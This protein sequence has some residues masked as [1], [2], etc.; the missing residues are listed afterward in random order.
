MGRRCR[1]WPLFVFA[2]LI[3]L[4]AVA[5][6]DD[7]EAV[8]EEAPDAPTDRVVERDR[9][10]AIDVP[11]VA[12]VMGDDFDPDDQA[13]VVDPQHWSLHMR[14]AGPPE[15]MPQELVIA[16]D[17]SV[18]RRGHPAVGEGTRLSIEGDDG[19][20]ASVEDWAITD[21][22]RTLRATLGGDLSP[23]TTYTATLEALEFDFDGDEDLEFID[24]DEPFQATFDTPATRL[25]DVSPVRPVGS[26]GHVNLTFSTPVDQA[27]L[28]DL[29]WELDGASV[30]SVTYES[31][32]DRH[33][34]ARIQSTSTPFRMANDAAVL[35][36]APQ[37]ESFERPVGN[38]SQAIA[39]W[40]TGLYERADTPT[41]RVICH[42]ESLDDTRGF[43]WDSEIRTSL[44]DISTRCDLDIERLLEHIAIDVDGSV[45]VAEHRHGVDLLFDLD[46][47]QGPVGLA[48]RSG[49]WADDGMPLVYEGI[50]ELLSPSHPGPSIHL[51]ADGRYLRGDDWSRVPIRHR[52]VEWVRVLVRH[53]ADAHFGFWLSGGDELSPDASFAVAE[54]Y[55]QFDPT[56]DDEISYIDL[57]ALVGDPAP[58][59]YQI[60]VSA[61]FHG[62]LQD[63]HRLLVSDVQL[64]AKRASHDDQEV[65]EVWAWTLDA[66]SAQPVEDTPLELVRSNGRVLAECRTD[67]EGFCKLSGN[68]GDLENEPPIA[69]VAEGSNDLAYIDWEDTRTE[70][71]EGDIDGAPYSDTPPYRGAIA[72]ER[73]LYRPGETLSLAAAIRGDGLSA[74]ADLPVGIELTDARQQRAFSGV[75][76]ADESGALEWTY[77]IP[78]MAPTGTWTVELFSGD[79]TIA[80]QDLTVEEFVPDRIDVDLDLDERQVGDALQGTLQADYFF[81]LPASDNRYEIECHFQP[82]HPFPDEWPNYHFGPF[83]DE[84]SSHSTRHS[85]TLDDQGQA[86]VD[87]T[88]DDG[89]AAA[90][91]VEVTAAVFEG[92]SGRPARQ[93]SS[94]HLITDEPLVGLRSRD[95]RADADDGARLQGVVVDAAGQ[96][97]DG[98]LE[99]SMESGAIRYSTVRTH[100]GGRTQW[101]RERH[102]SVDERRA[103]MVNDG[104]FSLNLSPR[105]INQGIYARVALDGQFTELDVDPP[106]RHWA[107]YGHDQDLDPRPDDPAHLP[108]EG[109]DEVTVGEPATFSFD[110]PSEGRALVATET[111]RVDSWQ[112]LDV[113]P[114]TNEWTVELDSFDPNIYVSALFVPTGDD[115]PDEMDRAFGVTRVAVNRDHWRADLDLHV[116]SERQ[117]GEMLEISV[118]APDAGP[119]A[120]VAIAAVDRGILSMATISVDDPID[121]LFVTRALGTTTFDTVGWYADVS[122]ERFGG[123]AMTPPPPS[124]DAIM[125]VRPTSM[126][127]GLLPVEE[128]RAS[129]DFTIPDFTGE[130]QISAFLID[131]EHL[132]YATERT[133]VRDPLTLQATTPRFATHDDMMEIPLSITNTTDDPI[134]AELSAEALPDVMLPGDDSAA[135]ELTG[136]T[137]FELSLDPGERAQ[138]FVELRVTGHA[139]APELRFEAHGGGH[140]SRHQATLPV[141]PEGIAEVE[142]D[143][144]TIRDD[145]F[146]LSATFRGWVPTSETSE[147]WLTSVP[148]APAFR[149]LDQL[150]HYPLIPFGTNLY[151]TVARVRPLLHLD[152]LMEAADPEAGRPAAP[153]RIRS[154]LHSV[155]RLQDSAGRFRF[156]P[157]GWTTV[158][159]YGQAFVLDMLT[160]ADEAG[161]DLPQGVLPK[162]LDWLDRRVQRRQDLQNLDLPLW[163]LSRQGRP[164][165][166]VARA[167]LESLPSTLEGRD[168]ERA[169]LAT[170]ALYR[171]G[172]ET[173]ED[174]LRGLLED[175]NTD[176]DALQ[177]H[178]RYT[179]LR[180]QGL[181]LEVGFELFGDDP[182]LEALVDAVAHA[183]AS[184]DVGDLAID[185]V[186]WAVSG[187]GKWAAHRQESIPDARL[188][189]GD[190]EVEPSLIASDGSRSWSLHR[191]SEYPSLDIVFDEEP[192]SDLTLFRRTQ[193]V[194]H[195]SSVELGDSGLRFER[196]LRGADGQPLDRQ[197]IEIG[198]LVFVELEVHNPSDRTMSDLALI[199]RLPG[200]LEIEDP[201]PEGDMRPDWYDGDDRWE[202][203]HFDVRDDRLQLYGDLDG[204]Q[205]RT[206]IYSMRATTAGSFSTPPSELISTYHPE[207]FSRI[208]G[209]PVQ[210]HRP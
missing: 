79:E 8:D 46:E 82:D 1:H 111:D 169:L 30:A 74:E 50:E 128:G 100:S 201:R 41:L 210:I 70:I 127:S 175:V 189:A 134:D 154:G 93:T 207:S 61:P 32:S 13:R 14:P 197:G 165:R 44:R 69:V 138:V 96:P 109:P 161:H 48:L 53:A 40:Q 85:G 156:W 172:D 58:G 131:D 209:L 9:S 170:A 94:A 68:W 103:I 91:T 184:E 180:H 75:I 117:P 119:N 49:Q 199:D 55:L 158:S 37:G 65:D 112:W 148:H 164:N 188:I 181:A 19:S 86:T 87:C 150:L 135:L 28:D 206:F 173:V 20:T 23:D 92:A 122:P 36:N 67:E 152:D 110:A 57:Q 142:M 133:T 130:L 4:T 39:V 193:G 174:D 90:Y 194:R 107:W 204:E 102:I 33:H 176:T 62:G 190:D 191:A 115:A 160:T 137:D 198:D 34:T 118:D 126:W 38:S 6:S 187:L 147:F 141:Y 192:T 195:D 182:V 73:T 121:Q 10:A 31:H 171:G 108:L 15:A 12:G 21:D 16:I 145:H 84:L 132:G 177:G 59:A 45:S 166:D 18:I 60:D 52:G 56:A 139:G 162:G 106:Q 81:G 124:P 196:T 78:D 43:A 22:H 27:V 155:Q 63:S 113:G 183:L 205:T 123:G 202:I 153:W 89:D 26:Y 151:N 25:I 11:E 54:T 95:D 77:D 179:A 76:D 104:R 80:T 149:H 101:E 167:L 129:V 168:H 178:D 64:I 17:R 186:G 97:M 47:P 42:D 71:V 105:G 208:R 88:P 163:V 83:D 5:C 203:D 200:G 3:L 146:D 51:E 120:Q 185:Q 140:S 116:P 159:P 7:E 99:L 157:Q 24:F 98:D 2:I 72:P 125:P 29:Q 136:T 66:D 114:G 35:S 144:H 143:N